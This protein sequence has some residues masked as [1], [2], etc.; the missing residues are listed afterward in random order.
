[1]AEDGKSS[2][3]EPESSNESRRNFLK[4]AVVASA[5][6]AVGGIGAVA[7]S[8][9]QGAG[10]AGQTTG[11]TTFPRYMIT[12][13]SNLQQGQPI[14]FNYPLNNEPNILV[15]LGQTAENGI[16]PDK[17]IVAFSQLCQHVGCP[18]SFVASG[19]APTCNS[20]YKAKGPIGYCCCHGS[21]YDF[22]NSAKVIGGPAPRPVPQVILDIDSSGNIYA[23]GMNPPTIFGYDTGSTDVTNDLQGG[24][25]VS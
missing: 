7:K 3:E 18:Y 22:L 14:Y 11:G 1:M 24:T 21:Q 13:I 20:S 12:N 25:L 4:I 15:K 5:L 23:T 17:D 9:T 19:G 2:P 6:L 16:G 8:V 10:S